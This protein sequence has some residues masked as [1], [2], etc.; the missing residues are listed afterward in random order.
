MDLIKHPPWLEVPMRNI[1]RSAMRLSTFILDNLEAI[2]QAWEA[3]ARSVNRAPAALDEKRLRN[4]AEQIL[5]TIALDMRTPQSAEQQIDKSHGLGPH[6]VGETPAQTH[7]VLRLMDGFSMDQ[8]VAEYRALRSSVLRLWRAQDCPGGEHQV[9]D[10]MRFNEAIDQA[11]VESIQSYGN[12]VETTRKTVLGVLGHDLR[13]PLGAMMMGAELL[14]RT[15]VLAERERDIAAQISASARRANQMVNDLLDL[16]R[17]NLGTGIPVNRQEIELN[18]ICRT[19]VDELKAGHPNAQIV[20]DDT[21]PITGR[22]DPLR[23]AQVFSN[24]IGNAVRHG[25]LHRPIHVNL[26]AGNGI[27]SFDVRNFGRPIPESV[28]PLL[29]DP[30]GRFSRYADNQAGVVGGLGLGLFIAAEIV[31]GHGGKIAVESTLDQGTRFQ[32]TLPAI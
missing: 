29:F 21:Q 22:F 10:M 17:C 11:L 23:M 7:A 4:R 9:D 26:R 16:A 18:A 24:L 8:M 1:K 31:T 6:S 14:R 3:F 30:Q 28:L 5:I 32:V 20:F 25:D 12:A 27:T 19:V 2:L 13:S 15:P